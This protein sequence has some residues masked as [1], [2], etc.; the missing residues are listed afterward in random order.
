MKPSTEKDLREVG[1]AVLHLEIRNSDPGRLE[2]CSGDGYSLRLSRNSLRESG[3]SIDG[4]S[5]AAPL[6]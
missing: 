1:L 2:P 4:R 6:G 5:Y 3:E